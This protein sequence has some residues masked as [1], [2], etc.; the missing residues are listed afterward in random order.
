MRSCMYIYC[1]LD[2]KIVRRLPSKE[3]VCIY[4]ISVYH[5]V[6]LLLRPHV[7]TIIITLLQGL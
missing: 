7:K 4:F 5:R 3:D 6:T 1:N 2:C